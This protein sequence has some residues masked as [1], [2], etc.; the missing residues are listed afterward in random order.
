MSATALAVTHG[1]LI[2]SATA[3]SPLPPAAC[4]PGSRRHSRILARL[5]NPRAAAAPIWPP[6]SPTSEAQPLHRRHHE[7][8]SSPT[9]SRG[10]ARQAVPEAACTTAATTSGRRAQGMT[11]PRARSHV[12]APSASKTWGPMPR[13][14]KM[15]CRPRWRAPGRRPRKEAL[16]ALDQGRGAGPLVVVG[17]GLVL[18]G[19]SWGRRRPSSRPSPSS[20]SPAPP[21]EILPARPGLPR[22]ARGHTSG[23]TPAR[24]PLLGHALQG[25]DLPAPP[26]G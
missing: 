4:Q 1:E 22:G 18:A 20:L 19:V 11:G 17:S 7:L 3:L 10:W 12:G 26:A 15:A 14:M 25:H 16:G 23:A 8:T 24:P 9:A 2:P 13:W 5:V 6:P 21:A